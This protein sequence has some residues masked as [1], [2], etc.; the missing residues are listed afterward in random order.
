MQFKALTLP[1]SARIKTIGHKIKRFRI[2]TVGLY[3]VMSIQREVYPLYCVLATH[4][5]NAGLTY[6][7]FGRHQISR[8]ERVIEL[9]IFTYQNDAVATIRSGIGCQRLE[10]DRL[11]R[12][13]GY[14]RPAFFEVLM[15]P[16]SVNTC[17]MA[18]Q[19]TRRAPASTVASSH[20]NKV[21]L[22]S[23]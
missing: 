6:K 17:A 20:Q 7:G 13:G 21:Q 3:H 22:V 11:T 2:T 23:Q 15:P 18:C 5:P 4:D 12:P 9:P 16:L 8:L 1:T 14:R 10:S 19:A